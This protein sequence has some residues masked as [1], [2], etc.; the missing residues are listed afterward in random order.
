MQKKTITLQETVKIL[1]DS[2]AVIWDDNFL[3]YPS[4]AD[5]TGEDDNEFLRLFVVDDEG[6]EYEVRFAEGLNRSVAV[7]SGCMFLT[8]TEG[9]EVQISILVPAKL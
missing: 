5:L 2:A 7:V 3:C 1:T 9:N 8:D 4:V 6:L